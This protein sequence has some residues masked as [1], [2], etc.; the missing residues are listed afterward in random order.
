MQYFTQT[1]KEELPDFNITGYIY[2]HKETKAQLVKLVS[3][4]DNKSFAIS[5]K[6]PPT[7]SKGLPHIVEHSVLCGSD[8]Y[9]TKEP[10]ADL[11]RGSLQNFLNAFTFPD[12]TM[13][14]IATVNNVDYKNLMKIYLDGVFLPKVRNDIYPFY[15]E[16]RRWEKN[17]DGLG[18]NGI[19]YNEMKEEE[20]D[21]ITLACRVIQ[22]NLYDG[23]YTHEAGGIPKHIEELTYDEFKEFYNNHYHPSNSLSVCY[24]PMDL[25]EDEMIILNDYFKGRGFKTPSEVIDKDT[26]V[27]GK[28]ETIEYPVDQE[29][30]IEGKDVFVYSWKINDNTPETKFVL[31][32]IKDLLVTV[33]G[34]TLDE[35]LKKLGIGKKTSVRFETDFI[36]PMFL[37]IVRDADSKRFEEFKTVVEEELVRVVKEGFDKQRAVGVLNKQEFDL[38]EANFGGYPKGIIYAMECAY[39]HTHGDKD[40]FNN[41]RM[42]WII[43]KARE[44]L[45]KGYLESFIQKYLIDN[46]KTVCVKCVPVR[47]LTEKWEIETKQRHAEMSKD[48]DENK[49]KEIEE[50][51]AE[52]K[53]RQQAED[54]EEQI[55]TIPRLHLSD[56]GKKSRDVSLEKVENSIPT[57]RKIL[58]TNGITYFKYVFDVSDLTREELSHLDFLLAVIKSFNTEDHS[59]LTLGALIDIYFGKL[60]FDLTT[61]VNGSIGV[62]YEQTKDVKPTVSISGKMLNE[63]ITSG[64]EVLGEILTRVKFEID[65]FKKKLNE[66]IVQ[67]ET[68]IKN[69]SFYALSHRVKSYLSTQGVLDE[70]LSGVTS[71]LRDVKLQENFEVEGEK[72]LAQMKTMYE[73]IFDVSRVTLFYSSEDKTKDDVL[74]QLTSLQK[75]MKGEKYATKQ[76]YDEPIIKNEALTIPIKINYVST[77]FNFVEM[78]VTYSEYLWNKVRVEGGAYGCWLIYS[79]SGPTLFGSYRDPKLYDTLRTYQEVEKYI[80]NLNFSQDDIENYLIG[81]FADI[82][83]PLTVASEF[84][85]CVSVH[86][87]NTEANFQT[88]RDQLF[89]LNLEKLK[90]E[91]KHIIDGLKKNIICSV[92]SVDAVK[93]EENVFKDTLVIFSKGN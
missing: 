76:R 16:G 17:D 58:S 85:S 88:I 31:D 55:A 40:T 37:I 11:L 29:D 7:N 72:F 73:R 26:G 22:Q 74:K 68:V 46:K 67:A 8:N 30:G 48:F 27:T 77:A 59:F 87:N 13:Y 54:T 51:C 44:G 32:V 10:F 14:P 65:I 79:N 43:K 33:E 9:T 20:T 45:E 82:D 38:K 61:N 15:Q 50:I 71:Y 57:Y 21:P 86:L 23:T 93:K 18:I 64:L 70:Y 80:S 66:Y 35:K 90:N 92:T 25:L 12:H 41:L 6:T 1:H 52:L 56:I 49:I 36:N 39:S 78:G 83:K 84:T 63:S 3:G 42:N 91:G 28:N 62:S 5:L 24:S 89:E 19:V 53:K 4:D 60:T 34:A 75:Y 81:I 2:E 69:R 47:G